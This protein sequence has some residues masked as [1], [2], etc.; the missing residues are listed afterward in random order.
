M[1][2]RPEKDFFLLLQFHK[3][4]LA[5]VQFEKSK[6]FPTTA[7]NN[8]PTTVYSLRTIAILLANT[9]KLLKF[10]RFESVQNLVSFCLLLVYFAAEASLIFNLFLNFEQK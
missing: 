6:L 4:F 10:Y 9:R 5:V 3:F 8:S 7:K 2:C 1:L